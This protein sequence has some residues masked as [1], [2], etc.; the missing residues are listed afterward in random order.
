VWGQNDSR[1][2][3]E[4][5]VAA[6]PYEEGGKLLKREIL[7]KRGVQGAGSFRHFKKREKG[8]RLQGLRKSK[9]SETYGLKRL[10]EKLRKG[11]RGSK[12]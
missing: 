11:R 1:K 5:K 7:E 8:V 10:D 6:L 9:N 4:S 3:R 12:K 2:E